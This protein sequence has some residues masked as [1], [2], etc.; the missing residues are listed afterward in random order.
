MIKYLYFSLLVLLFSCKKETITPKNYNPNDL[1]I[2]FQGACVPVLVEMLYWKTDG[3]MDTIYQVPVTG[4]LDYDSSQ[5]VIDHYPNWISKYVVYQNPTYNEQILIN[6]VDTSKYI[7]LTFSKYQNIDYY[8]DYSGT[9]DSTST[10][11]FKVYIGD[12]ELIGL[13]NEDQNKSVIWTW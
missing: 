1:R 7:R 11:N 6:D 13:R 2:E 12:N 3:T 8:I 9:L 10:I 4:I 5:Y